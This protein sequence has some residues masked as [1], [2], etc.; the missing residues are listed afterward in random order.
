MDMLLDLASLYV[1]HRGSSNLSSSSSNSEKVGATHGEIA[2]SNGIS[3]TY[4]Q[5]NRYL[6]LILLAKSPDNSSISK[7]DFLYTHLPA[8]KEA[9]LKVIAPLNK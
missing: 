9:I 1:H 3:V 4:H 5:I 2:L 8:T 7:A 6:C